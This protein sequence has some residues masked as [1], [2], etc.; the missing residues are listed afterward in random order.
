MSEEARYPDEEDVIVSACRY[1]SSVFSPSGHL[2]AIYEKEPANA[3]PYLLDLQTGETIPPSLP[4]KSGV[5]FLTDNL[6]Y[7]SLSYEENYVLDRTTEKQYPIYRFL[8]SRPNAY[9][10]SDIDPVLL[11]EILQQAKYVFFREGDDSIV[12]LDPNFPTS[13]EN[14]FLIERFDIP[15]NNPNRTEQFLKEYNIAHETIPVAYPDKIFSPDGRFVALSDGIY[16]VQTGQR[17]IE[18][19]TIS[20]FY[21]PYSGKYFDVRG[22]TYDSR[23]VVY[24]ELFNP[25]L[26]ETTLITIDPVCFIKVP[27]PLIKLKVPEE[28]LQ[29]DQLP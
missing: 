18:G 4:E 15:G 10:G 27:Q 9:I 5:S 25:C 20:R 8:L 16:W 26:I 6:L 14:N 22:W 19:P 29:S 28:Y 24:S 23:A 1:R 2:L 21:R 7:I 12:S 3:S 13:A 17:I 11:A